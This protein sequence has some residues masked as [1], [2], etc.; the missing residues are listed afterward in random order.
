MCTWAAGTLPHPTAVIRHLSPTK[1]AAYGIILSIFIIFASLERTFKRLN[2]V[3]PLKNRF[4]GGCLSFQKNGDEEPRYINTQ[5]VFHPIHPPHN[6]DSFLRNQERCTRCVTSCSS[7]VFNSFQTINYRRKRHRLG[8]TCFL[9]Q[10]LLFPPNITSLRH[11]MSVF[12]GLSCLFVGQDF[13]FVHQTHSYLVVRW[14]ETGNE[15]SA[16]FIFSRQS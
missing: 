11:T 10:W 6:P 2:H 16:F 5:T 13:L 12:G 7:S 1:H 15:K 8:S 4:K 14:R 9:S 3:S